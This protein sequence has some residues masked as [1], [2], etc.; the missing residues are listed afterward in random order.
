MALPHD[1]RILQAVDLL[2]AEACDLEHEFNL[3]FPVFVQEGRVTALLGLSNRI[4][5]LRHLAAQIESI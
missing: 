3:R 2:K 5:L 1:S 4:H